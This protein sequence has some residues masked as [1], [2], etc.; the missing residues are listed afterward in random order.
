MLPIP[1]LNIGMWSAQFIL[2]LIAL[3]LGMDIV[4]VLVIN[5]ATS[6]GQLAAAWWVYTR[7][8][9]NGN[10]E[11]LEV[12]DKG[13][14]PLVQAQDVTIGNLLRRALPFAIGAALV[15]LQAR[16]GT[17]LLERLSDTGQTGYYAAANRFVE[18]G[19]MLPNAFFGALFPM[20]AALTLQPHAMQRVFRH[21]LLTLGSFGLAFGVGVSLAAPLLIVLYGDAFGASV[22]VLR[23]LAW[24][25][26]PV[27][28]RAALTLYAYA[29]GREAFA[30]GVTAVM[31]ALQVVFG[32]WI[33]PQ[34]GAW[35]AAWVT[36]G[37]E[38]MGCMLMAVGMIYLN[39]QDA[40]NAK[41]D[42]EDEYI[43]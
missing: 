1:L 30:N 35:G 34:Y 10:R 18:A 39:R 25:L 17:I 22:A 6:A 29:Q 12:S 8:T 43:N 5:I 7:R 9:H 3:L 32:L 26:L 24:A 19:R 21:A 38:V 2:T 36:L 33:I 15:A 41:E 37:V 40:K 28:L 23:V 4:A 16:A 11:A 27:V 42:I 14:K 13:F 31:L 20:L